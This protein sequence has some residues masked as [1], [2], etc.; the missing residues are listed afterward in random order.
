MLPF[1]PKFEPPGPG[2]ISFHWAKL[3]P[4]EL[5]CTFLIYAAPS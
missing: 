1:W 5:H 3:H 2:R 4:S